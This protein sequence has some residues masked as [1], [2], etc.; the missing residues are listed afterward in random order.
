MSNTALKFATSEASVSSYIPYSTH[1]TED[2]VSTRH[3]D[4]LSVI[5][6]DGRSHLSASQA[7]VFDWVSGL[8]KLLSGLASPHV[9]LWTHV[10]RRKVTEYPD[11]AF[12]N[13]FCRKLDLKYRESF[14]DYNLM[15][16]ELYL[17]VIYRPVV[18]G[19]TSFFS[20]LERQS[21]QEKAERQA[22]CI[23]ALQEINRTL[24]AGLKKSY[25]A[26]LLSTEERNGFMYSQVAEFLSYL[27]NL[28]RVSV[29]LT[30]DRLSD[31]LPINRPHFAPTSYVGEM[32]SVSGKSFFGMLDIFDYPSDTE[33]G[34]F[35][36][37]LQSDFEFILT[38]SMSIHS[39][40][41]ALGALDRQQRSLEDAKD[42]SESQIL[43]LNQLKD[44]IASGDVFGG[45]HHC[46][47]TVLGQNLRKVERDLSNARAIFAD[48]GVIAKP[49]D[50]ALEAGFWAQLPCNYALR[51]RPSF[52]TSNNFLS[53]SSLHNFLSGKPNG[54][55]WGEAVTILKTVSKTPLYFNFHYSKDDIDATDKKL[56]GN[57]MMTGMSGTGKTV[58]LTFLLS[59]AQKFGAS[60]AFF[61]KD[62]GLEVAI[63]F[64]GGRYQALKT[65]EPTGFNPFQLEPTP[66]NMA[67][68]RR[69]VK[70]LAAEGG[71]VSH[72]DEVQIDKALKVL[73]LEM[74]K[75]LRRMQVLLQSLPNPSNPNP[76]A[77]P[78][79]HA[80][81][82]K[83]VE[84]N[85]LGWVFD[86]Q[87]DS[88]DLSTH[89]LYGFDVTEFLDNPET[90]GP[91]MMYLIYRT[92][93]MIDG[94]RFMYGFDE[95]WK[96]LQ[97]QYF[98]ELIKNKQKTIR[99][100]NGLC[101]F[102]TQE[103]DDLSKS[104]IASTLVSQ[105]ATLIFLPNP[106]A[107]F[108]T[109]TEVLKLTPAEFEV[110][111]GLSEDSRSF[112]IKQGGSIAVAKLDLHGFDDELLVLSGTPE[113]AELSEALANEFGEHPDNW[114]DEFFIRAK[115]LVRGGK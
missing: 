15:V 1:V 94:R 55:P 73:M 64:M 5:K 90:R 60:A 14:T 75:P 11:S 40:H 111:R 25:G 21:R 45:L 2:I 59:Q 82:L 9:I 95:F 105:C 17:T 54:N 115:A 67:F 85:Q 33:P 71:P 70:T 76:N 37:L 12:E 53:F 100:Q 48:V 78:S 107:D 18:D 35:N 87:H 3:G 62:R 93:S 22:E 61:D 36:S 47:L 39:K 83:W 102:A 52:I 110:L 43:Q 81:L 84:G 16:N 26:E 57:T 72:T 114:S 112:M 41:A 92:E 66:A 101:V 44:M 68:L 29:P 4:Y 80:R 103:V 27:I 30:K 109:Y 10:V 91:V 31:A 46:S 74:P 63:R 23:K 13:D 99:K 98:E 51:P 104:P 6:L 49:V 88:I 89:K 28:E 56:L 20:A 50:S 58:L 96:P 106:R 34:H 79:V 65:G 86:N 113:L 38:Q 32:S 8:N 69:F 108:K 97:D 7:D 19:I 24:M 77:A 42:H